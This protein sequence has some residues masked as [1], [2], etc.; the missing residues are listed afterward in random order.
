M[1]A[2]KFLQ[3]VLGVATSVVA[4]VLGGASA[5]NQIVATNA[6]GVIDPSFLPAGIG[7]DIVT[8]T[9]SEALAGGALVSFYTNAGAF[10]VRN[11]DA[12]TPTAGKRASGFVLAAVA[13][14]S[15]ASVYRSGMNTQLSG[16]T[17]GADYFLGATGAVTANPP[18]ASGTTSQYIG[19]A[20]S[21]TV[22]DVQIQPPIVIQ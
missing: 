3:N 18:T 12:G 13:S 16:L 2:P 21:A 20:L 7:A 14:G 4:A 19:T 1:A 22:L 11:A 5:A 15:V 8:G 17:P 9:A 6:A 10:S